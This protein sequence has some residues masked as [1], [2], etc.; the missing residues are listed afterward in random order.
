MMHSGL[1]PAT[2]ELV[3]HLAGKACG[4]ILDLYMGYNKQVLAKCSRDLTTF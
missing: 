1:L 3:M 4:G 2:E